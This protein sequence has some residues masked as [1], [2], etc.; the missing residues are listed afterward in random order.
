M[1]GGDV[2]AGRGTRAAAMRLLEGVPWQESGTPAP[3]AGNGAAM[4]AG[5]VGL[6]FRDTRAMCRA[7][8]EQA[9]ITHLDPRCAAGSVVIARAVALA[10]QRRPFHPSEFI[11]DLATCAAGSDSSVA[12]AVTGLNDWIALDSD[13]SRSAHASLRTRSCP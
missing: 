4:R 11:E 2:G 10:A 9:R 7:A 8:A 3:Y 6:L 5:P 13:R 1:S 12:A